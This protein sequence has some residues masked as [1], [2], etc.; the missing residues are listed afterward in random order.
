MGSK[1]DKRGEAMCGVTS[2]GGGVRINL[3]DDLGRIFS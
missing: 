2:R 1:V 3:E